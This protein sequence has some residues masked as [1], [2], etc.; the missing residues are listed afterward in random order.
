MKMAMLRIHE[1][2][3]IAPASYQGKEGNLQKGK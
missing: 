1:G 2:P 3:W